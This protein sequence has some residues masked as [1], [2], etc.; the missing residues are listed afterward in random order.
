MGRP[1]KPALYVLPHGIEVIGEYAPNEACPYWRV[2]I[3]PHPFFEG[4]P[5]RSNGY[6]VRRARVLLAAKLGRPLTRG[7]HAHHADEDRN[8]EE[9]DNLEPLTAAEHNRHHKT[10]TKHSDDVRARIA[11]SLRSAYAEGRHARLPIINRDN[12]GRIAQ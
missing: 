8:N 11:E 7:E 6:D 4:T 9:I 1:L 5:L 10:G 2:R 3:R 12:I